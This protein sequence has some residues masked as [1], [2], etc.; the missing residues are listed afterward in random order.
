MRWQFDYMGTFHALVSIYHGDGSVAIQHAGVEMGQ[1]INTKV[2][3]VVGHILGVPSEKISVKTTTSILPNAIGSF[4]SMTSE[5]V[6]YVS[7]FLWRP[8]VLFC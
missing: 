6:C 2:V 7:A 4:N 5:S 8:L 1:G 3:Q